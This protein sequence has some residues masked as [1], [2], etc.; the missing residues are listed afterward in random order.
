ML[1]TEYSAFSEA[2]TKLPREHLLPAQASGGSTTMRA[3]PVRYVQTAV[4]ST[5]RHHPLVLGVHMATNYPN[6]PFSRIKSASLAELLLLGLQPVGKGLARFNPPMTLSERGGPRSKDLELYCVDV[7][8]TS[9]VWMY[10]TVLKYLH[11]W[12]PSL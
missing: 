11:Y 12:G 5:P 8:D 4:W 10:S 2:A 3:V 7:Q 1:A 9:S 6:L